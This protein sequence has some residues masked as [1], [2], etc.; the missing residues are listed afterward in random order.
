MAGI[1]FLVSLFVF[2]RGLDIHGLEFRDDEIFYFQSTKEMVASGDYLSPT[3]QGKN[4]FQKPILFYWMIL[5]SYKIFGI[6]W[7]GARFVSVLCG[8][9][10][11]VLT[12]VLAEKLFDKRVALLSAPI[13]M[14]F[15]LFFRHAKNA[16]PDMAMNFFIVLSCY[17]ALRVL[18]MDKEKDQKWSWVF[19]VSC[20]LG[21]MIKGFAALIV[22]FGTVF[23]YSL[24]VKS[25]QLLKNLRFGRGLF[26]MM[27]IIL[28][29]FL[30][31]INLH[32]TAYLDYMF[33]VET[34]GRLLGSSSQG[35]LSGLKVF[36]GGVGFYS[37]TILS[38]FAPWSVFLLG[39]LPLALLNQRRKKYN[40]SSFKFCLSWFGVV[41]F[42]FCMMRFRINHYVLVL[43]TPAAI[44]LSV[45]FSQDFQ[46][47]N[48]LVKVVNFLR[49]YVPLFL[50]S[51]GL[52]GFSFLCFFIVGINVWWGLIFL[53]GYG[54]G[55]RFALFKKDGYRCALV[56]AIFLVIIFSQSELMG[57]A[58]FT[59][60]SSLQKFAQTI[61]SQQ[62]IKSVLSVGSHDIH[63][64]E[65]QVYF[66]KE[67]RKDVAW[68]DELT[69]EK[70]Y[71][72][73]KEN[74]D[75]FCLI[76]GK[77]YDK[78]L[79]KF[80]SEGLEIIQKEK[81]F[82]KRMNIDKGFFKALVRLDQIEIKNY[83]MEEIILV[84][85]LKNTNKK[86]DFN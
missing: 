55:L 61:K 49:I 79:T 23:M 33:G 28:P 29:W 84:R 60:H 37:E 22:P 20:G 53:V 57:K 47:K 21:F 80:G 18:N 25:G 10:S 76:M 75:V 69:Q 16:V 39:A 2:S 72:L 5:A 82:R 34:K 38:Y 40:C 52:I 32:G 3:Y 1:L 11:V 9:L 66:D 67:L 78:F 46:K 86:K 43:S 31:M 19:F 42:F 51:V 8:A 35:V 83:L 73:F 4:R 56:L 71:L 64:K 77:D 17:A 54:V 45:F 26:I 81:I 12:W 50:F 14:T 36:W 62:S 6:N 24:W 59:A 41:F 58:N 63:E 30:Y 48:G 13:L 74:E 70:L 44:L 27:L 65:F 7:V 15:S 85:N 68:N